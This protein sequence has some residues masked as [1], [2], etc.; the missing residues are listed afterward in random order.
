MPLNVGAATARRYLAILAL[1]FILFAEWPLQR[2]DDEGKM[3]SIL[4]AIESAQGDSIIG[5]PYLVRVTCS[6]EIEPWAT[7]EP[8]GPVG[9]DKAFRH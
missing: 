5:N 1:H 2:I 8:L 4:Q 3:R 7:L 9:R 6:Y